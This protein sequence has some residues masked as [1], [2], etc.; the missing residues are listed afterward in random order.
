[1]EQ[2]NGEKK[3]PKD[4]GAAFHDSFNM[5]AEITDFERFQVKEYLSILAKFHAKVRRKHQNIIQQDN[6]R[7]I[8][9]RDKINRI[10]DLLQGTRPLLLALATEYRKILADSL[11]GGDISS[12]PKMKKLV[13]RFRRDLE[14]EDK[15]WANPEIFSRFYGDVVLE[16]FGLDRKYQQVELP[17][18]TLPQ[19]NR[20]Q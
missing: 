19:N 20:T 3:G 7:L 18:K 11:N 5:I 6:E 8:Q 13:S 17:E 15:H 14:T 4:L 9:T 16:G 10:I 1:M 2:I 12:T